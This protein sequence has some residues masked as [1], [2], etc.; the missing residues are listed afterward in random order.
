M[1]VLKI[2]ASAPGNRRL[3]VDVIRLSEI[4]LTVGAPPML[5]TP[6]RTNLTLRRRFAGCSPT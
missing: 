5:Q 6:E 3:V 4:L 1:Q 2:V